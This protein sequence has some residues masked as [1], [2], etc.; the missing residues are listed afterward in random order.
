MKIEFDILKK[1]RKLILKIIEDLTIEQ[2]NNIPEGFNNNIV[3]N[4]A[5]LVVTQQLL[6]YNFS[7]LEMMV[8]EEM[9]T[10]FRKG[11]VPKNIVSKE[12]FET[13]KNLFIELPIQLERDYKNDV[14]KKY[15]EYNTSLNV[16]IVDID[17]AIDFNNYHEGIHLGIIL[18]I[19]KLV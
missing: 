2:L 19:I 3:W 18:G 13:Y 12:D 9:V 7:G 16:K 8:S 4:I 15:K 1:S 5:H 11:T 14:F 10:L 6:C 17:F